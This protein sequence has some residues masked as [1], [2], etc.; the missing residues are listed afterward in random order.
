MGNVWRVFKRDVR[1]LLK[2][3]P[4]LVVV[5]ALL[6]LPSVYTWYNVIGFWNPYDNTGNLRVCVV[7]EDAGGSSE[8][9]GELSVGDMI[10][11]ELRENTQLGWVFEDRDTAM[12][13]LDAGRAYA[14]FVIPKEFT[15]DLL[16]LTTGDFTQPNMEYYVNEKAGPVAPK[17]T[18][19]GATTLDETINS[20]FVSTVS[21]VAADAI[22]DAIGDM[23]G[24]TDQARSRASAKLLKATQTL[25]DA[26]EALSDIGET[27]EATQGKVCDA[28]ASLDGARAAADTASDALS[29]I[30]TLTAR[31]QIDL[32]N[33][34]GKA[35]PQVSESLLAISQASSKA[36]EAAGKITGAAGEAQGSIGAAIARAQTVVDESTA[37][38]A[39]LRAIVDGMAEDDPLK[40]P[41]EDAIGKLE[42]H[43][44]D[45]QEALDDLN[46]ANQEA[47]N[48]TQA[49]G[50]ASDALNAAVQ[51]ATGTAQAYSNSLFGTTIPAV[52][53]SL[54]QLSS[55]SAALSVA[56]SNQKLLIG[57]TGLVLD[58]LDSA[59][60]TAKDTLAQTDSLLGNLAS[61]F[62]EVQ[63]DV[64]ALNASDTLVRI[65]GEDGLDAGKIADFMGSPTELVT[66]Q[67]YELNA[68]GSAMAPLFMNLTFWIGA[69]MLLIIM[70]QEVDA[71]GIK[72]LTVTQRYMG[73]FLLLACMAV[74]QAVI[75]C[76]GVL[77]I[78]VQAEN[79]PALF[80]ASVVSSLAYLSIIYALSVTLQHI[81]K[82][83]CIILVFAQIPGA[84]GLY[85]I[86]MTPPFFQ[87]IYPFFP[88]TYGIS[89]MREAICGFYGA[90][91]QN[92][93]G[94]LGLFFVLSMAL[95]VLVRPL[96]ANV[97]RMV[98]DQIRE[99][100]LWNGEDVE[101]PS[102]PYRLS[103][104]FRALSGKEEYRAQL[105]YR[106]D[107]FKQWYPRLVRGALLVGL[108]VPVAITVV[109]ALTTTEKVVILT[110][111]LAW[112][113]FVFVFLV[114]VESLRFSIERQMQLDGMSVEG[115]IE[116]G[117]SRNDMAHSADD[118]NAPAVPD[119]L[120]ARA[121]EPTASN[122]AASFDILADVAAP[123]DVVSLAG[124]EARAPEVRVPRAPEADAP[125]APEA[126]APGAPEA[127][128]L[129]DKGSK[130]G[131]RRA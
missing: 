49:V 116:I 123:E 24:K 74:G 27:V 70:K 105:I 124:V 88:F 7:N 129:S 114:V 66:E 83:I 45:A 14:V 131:V 85:P 56:V 127:D 33:F 57:Q 120:A 80:L 1:R 32:A 99:S 43:N 54:A 71:E 75:C 125:G 76:A 22:D 30:A 86:E 98:A 50:Q 3:P 115:I 59:L 79:A 112:T 13:E 46:A 16:T 87:A 126:D 64:V 53:Q 15:S 48:M 95:G 17:I 111:M 4:A 6:V 38:I 92:A 36:N 28:R 58:Q 82:G 60:S 19:T 113:A 68:Y 40:K 65:F 34:T 42:K 94:M 103:Q 72:N 10:V 2:V 23:R 51:T 67:L 18:D 5:I 102:R 100:G 106:Y 121:A 41:V 90:H 104:I 78:G 20:T 35:S 29:A 122:T 37:A 61:D 130:G 39:S 44:A 12:G 97:N 119:S 91:Y 81:G 8:L 52:T 11:E 31:M 93:L 96:M 55:A 110:L 128:A 77:L 84:T 9:T 107:R 47:E 25:D 101:I 62:E 21:D 118:E 26:R 63:A 73:R 69:F 117:A 89:A 108:A 109:F